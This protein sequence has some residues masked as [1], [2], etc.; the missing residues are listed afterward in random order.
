MGEVQLAFETDVNSNIIPGGTKI[1]EILE[2]PVF[3]ASWTAI[4]PTKAGKTFTGRMSVSSI[5]FDVSDT[6]GGTKKYSFWAGESFDANMAV[7][8]DE[9]VFWVKP[10]SD[11]TFNL[12]LIG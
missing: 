1:V 11:G 7:S 10:A 4:T 8:A 12:M 3:A 9:T 2:V 6:V 5:A